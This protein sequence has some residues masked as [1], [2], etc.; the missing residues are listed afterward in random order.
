M[1]LLFWIFAILS[2]PVGLFVSFVCFMTSGLD[3]YGTGFG[4]VVCFLGMLTMV[5]CVAGIV[6]GIIKLRKGE[7][8]KAAL[9]ASM[10]LIYGV[11]IIAGIL[12]DDAAHSVRLDREIAER[13]EQRYGEN[14]DAPPAIE[15][16][17]KLYQKELNKLYA[18]VR[19]EWSADELVDL[20]VPKLADYYGDASL[21]NIGFVL[22]DVNSDG[23]DE[24]VI[25]TTAPSEEGGTVIFCIYSDP[26]NPFVSVSNVEERLYYLHHGEGN[27]YVAE[28]IGEDAAWLLLPEEG[29]S[30]VDIVYQEGTMDPAGRLTLELIPFSQYK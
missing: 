4:L 16:I 30:M 22:M 21:D 6:L 13:N 8:K 10:G 29:S 24:M 28:I 11:A 5:V 20:S 25:G 9:F 23:V 17:P 7:M 18:V 15:G 12:I 3:L 2:I 14:W 19:D 1:K 27:T 26:E